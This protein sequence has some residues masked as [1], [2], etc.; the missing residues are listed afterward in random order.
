MSGRT[1]SL[2]HRLY[3]VLE[4]GQAS[5][6]AGAIVDGVLIALILANVAA[7]T[8]QSVPAIEHAWLGDLVE[9]EIASVAIFTIEYALR[10]WSAPEDPLLAHY[11][12]FKGRLRY[13]M[14][15]LMIID[16]LA[17][18]PTYLAPFFP[19]LDF[20][21]LRLVRLLRLLKIARY[22]PA[23]STLVQVVAEERRALFGTLLLM[24]CA[25]VFAAATMHA[26]EGAVQ[27]KIFGT[28]PNSM[29]WAVTTL[30]TVGY[31]DAV[32][33]TALGAHDRRLSR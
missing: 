7:Y 29:W 13:A 22:S 12:T 25:T 21:I 20:R 3:V 8:L 2:R 6:I 4:G 9:F 11:S 24:L 1:T 33:I 17:I 14:R 32:P 31:G 27:P 10:L 28:I 23:L 18:A 16:F 5:G 26:A 15:P 30:T 19:L